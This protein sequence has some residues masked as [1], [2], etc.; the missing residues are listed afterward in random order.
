MVFKYYNPSSLNIFN[1]CHLLIWRFNKFEHGISTEN[2]AREMWINRIE[3]WIFSLSLSNRITLAQ[4]KMKHQWLPTTMTLDV[5]GA[6]SYALLCRSK[7]ITVV[8]GSGW[9]KPRARLHAIMLTP[10]PPIITMI[11][12]PLYVS[13]VGMN[14]LPVHEKLTSSFGFQRSFWALLQRS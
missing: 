3:M 14:L 11:G 5:A 4:P 9:G 12:G 2:P 10:P 6:A 8:G 13:P 1:G 7:H